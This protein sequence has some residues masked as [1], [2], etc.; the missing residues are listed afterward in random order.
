MIMSK[1]YS[2]MAT[3]LVLARLSLASARLRKHLRSGPGTR[4]PLPMQNNF[5]KPQDAGSLRRDEMSS[6]SLGRRSESRRRR[7]QG[8][9]PGSHTGAVSFPLA[10][11][12]QLLG[13]QQTIPCCYRR[14]FP[15]GTR[16]VNSIQNDVCWQENMKRKDRR[17]PE[18][19]HLAT[20]I[21]RRKVTPTRLA[22]PGNSNREIPPSLTSQ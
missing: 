13:K 4:A 21:Y 1:L 2:V 5:F 16:H 8:P 17:P 20:Y 6:V 11:S 19:V 3:Q 12:M 10:H 7:R 14:H 18:E 9:A 22:T 15:R